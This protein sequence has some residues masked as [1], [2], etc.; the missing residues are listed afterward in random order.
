[1]GKMLSPTKSPSKIAMIPVT[2]SK[3]SQVQKFL[4][5][6]SVGMFTI[7]VKTAQIL[8]GG[9][10]YSFL[11]S[12]FLYMFLANFWFLDD[13]SR[14]KFCIRTKVPGNVDGYMYIIAH[15]G[16]HLIICLFWCSIL[17]GNLSYVQPEPRGFFVKCFH[18]GPI[19]L[20]GLTYR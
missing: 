10:S 14:N 4:P 18:F 15:N 5:S 19:G 3:A 11:S 12:D 8:F 20:L 6:L 9:R 1:M 16:C 2:I 17:L 7:Y 13:K